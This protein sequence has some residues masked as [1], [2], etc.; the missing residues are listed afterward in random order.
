[1]SQDRPRG[2]GGARRVVVKI[3]SSVLRDGGAF[4]RVTFA[5]LVRD[6]V[7]LERADLQ[8]IVVCSGAVALGMSRLRL[9]SRPEQIAT[10]QAV[11]AVGQGKLMRMWNDEL[12]HYGRAAGQVLLTHDGLADRRRFLAARH[13]L[14]ALLELGAIPVINEND[15]VAIEE[16]K[17]GDNDLLSSQVVSLTD[18][19]ALVLLSDVDGFFDGD[20]AASTSQAI[21]HVDRV[22]AALLDQ[23]GGSTSG[24]GSGGMRT[25][26]EAMRQANRLGV[27]G[28]IAAGKT[29]QVLQRLM[30]GE[31]LGTWFAA[32][33]APMS[34]RKHWIAYA[35]R[36]A[37]T[38]RVDAGAAK[39]LREAG[40]SL[41]PA[42]LTK[43]EGDF[44][45]GDTVLIVDPQGDEVGR[46]LAAH[47]ATAIRAAVGL[48]SAALDRSSPA[49]IHRDDLVLADP[50]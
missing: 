18:A 1:M 43:V 5:S 34:K 24:L 15:T 30:D 8:V 36:P 44:E 40:R 6:V 23:A 26:V 33:P 28:V 48:Q 4:D 9:A 41:L 10:L 17:L 12:S 13:T 49:V 31:T 27:P 19:E 38:L 46:G 37:G 42:G 20:P 14:R 2:F 50:R 47:D 25:K 32:E 29:P 22:D 21:R 7:A 39:A 11:A 35:P 16:I 45:V 3:G